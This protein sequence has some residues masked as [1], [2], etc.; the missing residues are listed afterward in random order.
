M[1]TQSAPKHL[2]PLIDL[3]R[4]AADIPRPAAPC[5]PLCGGA[6]LIDATYNHDLATLLTPDGSA[7]FTVREAAVFQALWLSRGRVVSRAALFDALHRVV[8]GDALGQTVCMIR[9]RIRPLGMQITA[10]PLEG[11]RLHALVRPQ[12]CEG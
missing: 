7:K 2:Q 11:Y 8:D 5:C 12:V 6:V 10:V 3:A 9:R 1:Q 4:R